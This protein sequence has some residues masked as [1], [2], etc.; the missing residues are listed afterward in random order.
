[1][2]DDYHSV[3]VPGFKGVVFDVIPS[4]SV[5]E[6]S[7]NGW[8]GDERCPD[9]NTLASSACALF[10]FELHGESSSKFRSNDDQRLILSQ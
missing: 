10:C 3:L 6:F 1:M 2:K 8:C 7:L 9:E 4:I 5:D